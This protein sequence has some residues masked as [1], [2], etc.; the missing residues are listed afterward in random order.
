MYC[1]TIREPYSS[2]QAQTRSTK[3]S[4]PISWRDVPSAASIFST[5]AW[6]AMPAWSVPS[7]HSALR[8]RI[9][10][11]RTS[12]SCIAPFS[13]WPMCS[14]PVTFGGG[15]ATEK[16]SAGEPSACGWK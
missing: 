14:A 16:F 15:I 11:I 6:V 12:A 10:F 5:T 2:F 4:R 7:V 1:S 13:A 9:R 8:P 3:A